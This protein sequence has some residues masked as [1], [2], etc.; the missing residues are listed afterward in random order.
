VATQ[1]DHGLRLDGP[2]PGGRSGVPCVES[3]GPRVRRDDDIHQWHVDL[4]LGKDPIREE[5]SYGLSW[6]RQATQDAY[7]WRRVTER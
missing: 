1:M 4:V 3:D 2:R 5:R 7:R 6:D